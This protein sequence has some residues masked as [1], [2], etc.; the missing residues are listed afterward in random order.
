M[1]NIF[2]KRYSLYK[3]IE[4]DEL[5]AIT[6]NNF[7][8]ISISSCADFRL[9]TS[10]NALIDDACGYI[11]NKKSDKLFYAEFEIDSDY[12]N[13]LTQDGEIRNYI[14]LSKKVLNEVNSHIVERS[15]G[16]KLFLV[17]LFEYQESLIEIP[18]WV[19]LELK[20]YGVGFNS[21]YFEYVLSY[22]RPYKRGGMNLFIA[23][24][25]NRKYRDE[26]GRIVVYRREPTFY[27]DTLS[28]VL[29]NYDKKYRFGFE[30]LHVNGILPIS[31]GERYVSKFGVTIKESC[32]PVENEYISNF[33]KSIDD[34]YQWK[35]GKRAIKCYNDSFFRDQD[36]GQTLEEFKSREIRYRCFVSLFEMDFMLRSAKSKKDKTPGNARELYINSI[37]FALKRYLYDGKSV[38]Q[39]VD[40]LNDYQE[41]SGIYILC[42][43]YEQK[44][45]VGQ[46]KRSFKERILQH[47][48]KPQ[49]EFDK[50][51]SLEEVSNIYVLNVSEDCLDYVEM[52]CI[53]SIPSKLLFNVFA[54]GGSIEMITT[55]TY[56]PKR[57]LLDDKFISFIS[58]YANV[59]NSIK[60]KQEKN[61]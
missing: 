50:N 30:K 46:T 41:C 48:I 47:F 39:K 55:N 23:D 1:E 49:S 18:L 19:V 60:K 53:A 59:I 38:F 61:D 2:R 3:I 57:Y 31:K 20:K 24:L 27:E 8:Q 35:Y 14:S 33:K 15:N 32:I 40:N 43:D 12:Y 5:F 51:H 52:D 17:Q 58:E 21:E 25:Y 45:Y 34:L 13:Y 26:L 7:D 6:D 10:K 11:R 37:D 4:L 42:F 16:S 56:D 28:A 29:D 44:I 54:G 9:F 22:K 36:D